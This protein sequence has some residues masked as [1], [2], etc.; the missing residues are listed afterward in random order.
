[1]SEPEIVPTVTA[2][3]AAL[4]VTRSTVQAWLRQGAPRGPGG[5]F[6]VKAIAT[7]RAERDAPG[8]SEDREHWRGRR[9]RALAL[10][11]EQRLKVAS[12]ELIAAAERD[13]DLL[14]VVQSFVSALE[15]LPPKVVPLLTAARGHGEIDTILRDH[16][17][18]MR[19]QLAAKHSPTTP[20]PPESDG[21]PPL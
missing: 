1:M 17:R 10:E 11:A 13:A 15:N 4:G 8:P 16:I 21:A 12:G 14:A 2:V 7:W 5:R 20:C 6:D 19:I 18:T 9:E 3:A